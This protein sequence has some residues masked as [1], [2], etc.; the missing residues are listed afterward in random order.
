VAI[1]DYR[2]IQQAREWKF[3]IFAGEGRLESVA[4]WVFVF[5]DNNGRAICARNGVIKRATKNIGG[6]NGREES[7]RS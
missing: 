5:M 1:L 3:S 4:V 7:E 2:Q 6:Q